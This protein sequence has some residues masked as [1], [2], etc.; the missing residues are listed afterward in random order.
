MVQYK[1]QTCVSVI[2][3]NGI[4]IE[5]QSA[6]PKLSSNSLK[7]KKKDLFFFLSLSL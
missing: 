4:D 3:R 1:Y 7:I 2:T 6:V 5:N